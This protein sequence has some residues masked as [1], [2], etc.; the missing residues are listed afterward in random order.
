MI[1]LLYK[2]ILYPLKTVLSSGNAI[3]GTGGSTS[4]SISGSTSGRSSGSTS[5]SASGSTSGSTSGGTS[6]STS[7]SSSTSS[8]GFSVCMHPPPMLLVFY[9]CPCKSTHNIELITNEAVLEE[10]NKHL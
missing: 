3:G 9:K 4:G 5:G 1:S 10:W 8:I 2:C 7:G 6:G